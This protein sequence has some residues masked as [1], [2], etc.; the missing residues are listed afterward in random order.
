VAEQGAKQLSYEEAYQKLRLSY[1]TRLKNSLEAIQNVLSQ[2]KLGKLSKDDMAR[3]QHLVHGLAGSGTTFGFPKVTEAG[4]KADLFLSKKL[5]DMPDGSTMDDESFAGLE[6]LLLELREACQSAVEAAQTAE[7]Q[8]AFSNRTARGPRTFH[9]VVV[10]DDKEIGE[11]LQ[12]K[13]QQR[14]IRVTLARNGDAALQAVAKA[15]P[16]L[17]ILDISMPGMSGHEVLRRLKQ[18]PEYVGVPILMLTG[19]AEQVDVVSALHSGAIDYILKPFNPAALLARVEK[20]LDAARYTVLIADNDPLILQL[21]ES[22]FRHAGF[23]V[24]LAEDGGRAWEKILRSLPHLV[25]LDRMMPGL[26]G[27][28]VLTNMRGEFGTKNIP[29]ILLSACKEKRDIESGLQAGAQDYVTK[30]FLPDDLIS[31]SL[32]LLKSAGA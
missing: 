24:L 19:K 25:V 29:V 14:G 16:D 21:L 12:M 17:I 3:A 20:I 6:K 8:V 27:I 28:S 9:V 15:L 23:K 5:R 10:D 2:R 32:K 7:T 4:R 30:P 11:L 26:D 22:K 1:V 13:L 31:R 18:D